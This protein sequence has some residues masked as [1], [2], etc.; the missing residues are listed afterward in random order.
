MFI[1]LG[2][3]MAR[4]IEVIDKIEY[5]NSEIH[6]GIFLLKLDISLCRLL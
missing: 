3:V 6:R 4:F 1:G 5:L 2:L